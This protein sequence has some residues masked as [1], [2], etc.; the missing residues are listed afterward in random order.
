MG[1][2]HGP[3]I[4]GSLPYY[5]LY[6]IYNCWMI[7]DVEAVLMYFNFVLDFLVSPC[8]SADGNSI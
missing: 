2:F 6:V 7:Y 5:A 4:L 3:G 8:A 1:Y